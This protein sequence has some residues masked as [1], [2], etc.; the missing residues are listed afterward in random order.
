MRSVASRCWAGEIVIVVT[1]QPSSPAAYSANPPQPVPISS[2]CSPPVIP[3]RSAM[4]AYF[5][6]CASARV[7]PGRSNTA[8][9][10]VSVSS[11]NRR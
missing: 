11:R 2:T 5:R 8:L 6:R 7:R 9:E 3:A 10:Y 1:R 4:T